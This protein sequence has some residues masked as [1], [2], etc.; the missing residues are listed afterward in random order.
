MDLPLYCILNGETAV[1]V[2]RTEDGGAAVWEYY[3]EDDQFRANMGLLEC[4]LSDDL[5]VE[6]VPAARFDEFVK[7]L[8]SLF[9]DNPA[10]KIETRISAMQR[11]RQMILAA[12]EQTDTE[13]ATSLRNEF[14]MSKDPIEELSLAQEEELT[15]KLMNEADEIKTDLVKKAITAAARITGLAKEDE[16]TED[17]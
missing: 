11:A 4:I 5:G 14:R 15:R 9:E 17:I 12:V 2:L 6:H 10:L 1:K 3:P 16:R 13:R 7:N 8:K